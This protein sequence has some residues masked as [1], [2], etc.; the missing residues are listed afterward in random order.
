MVIL[1]HLDSHLYHT[2]NPSLLPD[3][4]LTGRI[5]LMTTPLLNSILA[6]LLISCLSFLGLVLVFVNQKLVKRFT[7]LL[8]SF[9]IGSLL[10]DAFIHLIP[11]SFA[12]ISP[13]H[14]ASWLILLGII[15][16]FIL[17]KFLLWHHCHDI[18]CHQ[19]SRHIVTLSLV[20]DTVHNFIDGA[21]IAASFNISYT[22]G[23]T[24]ALAVILHEIPQEIGDFGILIHHGVSVKKTVLY[25]FISSL[26]SLL[27]VILIYILDIDFS[28]SLIPITAGGFIYLAIADLM[29]QL[30]RHHS[31]I[32]SS[33]L[34]FL[35]LIFGIGLMSLL[36]F[37][38]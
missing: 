34:Q 8:V 1:Y 9:A 16:F 33:L 5:H 32:S 26:G 36:L 28:L 3:L 11:E 29:P 35:F 31:K 30:H 23:F 20:G 2:Q 14:L 24:T 13:R 7:P 27:G 21:L 12:S 10:G 22:V 18:D 38:D 6:S 4:I 17:E 15:L 37:L 25:N 19:D